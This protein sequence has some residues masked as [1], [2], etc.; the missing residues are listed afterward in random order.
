VDNEEERS[1]R[2]IVS[3]E[4]NL[5]MTTQGELNEDL[6]KPC[7]VTHK[8]ACRKTNFIQKKILLFILKGIQ[9]RIILKNYG[10]A[11]IFKLFSGSFVLVS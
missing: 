2:I 8:A 4:P 6:M 7:C 11:S 1:E 5:G 3:G 9:R 10:F